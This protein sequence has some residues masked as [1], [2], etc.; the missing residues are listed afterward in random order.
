VDQLELGTNRGALDER[1]FCR[2]MSTEDCL[3]KGC[4]IDEKTFAQACQEWWSV[5]MSLTWFLIF[6]FK[7]MVPKELNST[8]W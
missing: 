2:E 5:Q 8:P 1:Q 7:A 3:P 6:V 4:L